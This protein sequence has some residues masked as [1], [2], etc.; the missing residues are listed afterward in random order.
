MSNLSTM[1]TT[2]WIFRTL[3]ISLSLSAVLT[4][5]IDILMLRI[6]P[7][8]ETVSSLSNVIIGV[9][10]AQV[11]AIILVIT[12][13]PITTIQAE[14]SERADKIV[15]WIFYRFLILSLLQF[16]LS[17]RGRFGC[18]MEGVQI[19]LST[20]SSR[21]EWCLITEKDGFILLVQICRHMLLILAAFVILSGFMLMQARL[22][23]KVEEAT[24]PDRM[25]ID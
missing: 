19:E 25:A 14:A 5:I 10:A 24:E 22:Y 7:L 23:K 3:G 9:L 20:S 17:G 15:K 16:F 8:W 12:I 11:L 21:G 2:D 6:K 4:V 1:T 18:R 13:I